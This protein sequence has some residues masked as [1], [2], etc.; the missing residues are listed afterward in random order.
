[1]IVVQTFVLCYNI[2]D[3]VI[4]LIIKKFSK[5]KNGMYKL[6][7]EDDSSVVVHEEYILKN[8]L[9]LTKEIDIEDVNNIDKINNNYNAYDLAL[10][11]IGVKYRSC[12]EV[13]EYLLKKE[14]DK[15]VIHEV[16]EKLKNQKYLDD[17][18][19]AKAFVNDRIKF[20]NNGPYK[21]KRELEDKKIS[22]TI[23]D[24]VLSIFDYSFEKEKLEKLVPKYVKTIR[25]KSY[26]MMKNKVCEYFS[27]LGYNKSV[28]LDILEDIDYDEEAA[29]L[30][31]YNKLYN[32]LSRKYSGE[33][34]EFKIK[35][36]LYK[37]GYK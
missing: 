12:F 18:V 24:E 20:S 26:M 33:E 28:V 15:K 19:Y 31:E 22:N 37:N 4:I 30:K 34:L 14:V 35:Q 3:E 9:L 11:Y 13:H 7:L 1:M 6:L 25:N 36:G 5:Q 17:T 27:G 8:E 2:S 10:K 29:R 23:I 32:K 21:I 16:I